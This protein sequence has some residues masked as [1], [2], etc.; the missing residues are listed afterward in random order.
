[1]YSSIQDLIEQANTRKVP[2]SQIV[3][4]NE[5]ALTDKTEQEVYELLERH[6]EVMAASAKKALEQP[7]QMIGGS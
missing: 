2:L 4:E 5:M 6:Y 3:L 1:M 7:Q